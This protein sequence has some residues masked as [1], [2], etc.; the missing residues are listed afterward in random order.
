[1]KI[2]IRIVQFLVG[3]LFILSGLVKA[4]DPQGL[5]YKMKEFFEIWNTSLSEGHFFARS[6][7]I[8]L[9]EFLHEHSLFLSVVMITLEVIAG[10]ALIVAW[11]K[12]L[13]LYLL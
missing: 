12:K 7:L 8:G 9:F 3:L 4:N 2:L 5:S 13:V 11:R 10:V 1:M 6:A